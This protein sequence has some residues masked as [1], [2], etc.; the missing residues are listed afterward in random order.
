MTAE[1]DA[2]SRRIQNADK[3]PTA[4]EIRVYQY[5]QRAD[6]YP[7]AEEIQCLGRLRCRQEPKDRGD[8]AYRSVHV[9][10]SR[11]QS[12]YSFS[13]YSACRQEAN[14]REDSMFLHVKRANRKLAAKEI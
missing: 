4:E 2:V 12:R 1:E 7:M 3:K 5:D 10:A 6:K 8:T 14:G 11:L 13:E 9:Q